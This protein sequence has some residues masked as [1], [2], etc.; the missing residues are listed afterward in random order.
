MKP[1][2]NPFI[3]RS[4]ALVASIA[5]LCLG[6]AQ[7]TPY[8]WGG[9][10]LNWNDTT[11]SGWSGGPPN[12]SDTATINSG[13]VEVTAAITGTATVSIGAGGQL[14]LNANTLNV[15]ND[16]TLNGTTAGGAIVSGDRPPNNVNVLSGQ[17]TLASTSNIATWWNDK[18]LEISGKITGGGG[19]ILDRATSLGDPVGGK[20]LISGSTNDYAGGTTVNG[21]VAGSLYGYP[22]QAQVILGA[23][24]A[25]TSGSTLT[26]N[27]GRL[28]L[29]GFSQTLSDII[30]GTGTNSVRNGSATAGSLIMNVATTSSFGGI[31]G[32]GGTNEN[33]FSLTKNGIGTLT[34]SGANTY[35]GATTVSNG[36]LVVS[37]QSYFNV[38]R[39]TSIASGAVLELSNSNN[40]FTTL[41]PT[42]TVTGG[43]TFRLSGNS[44][45]NQDLNGVS[46]DRLT[47][48][49]DAGGLIDLQGTSRLT[50]GGWQEVKWTDNKAS[51]NIAS[52]AT[53]DV[54]D[55]QA[56]IIDALSGSGTVD[57]ALVGPSPSL[58]QVGVA[59][60][61]ETF[62]GTIKNTAGQLALTKVGSGTQTLSGTNSY[63]GATTVNGGI[64][65]VTGSTHATSAVTVGGSA[66]TALGT[67]KLTGSGTINGTV[68][69]KSAGGGAAG[70]LSAGDA[71]T[72]SKIGTLTMGSSLTF[73]SSSIFEWDINANKDG[74][75]VGIDDGTAGTDFDNVTVTGAIN[76][77]NAA[78]FKVVL[79]TGV[80]ITNAFWSESNVTQ[81]WNIATI[82]GKSFTTG[83]FSPTV[84]TN[85]DISSYGSFTISGSSL[86][87]TAVPEPTSALAGLLITAGLLRRRRK[88]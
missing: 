2:N 60:G 13:S 4:L 55:G 50:N 23:N 79:G 16:I 21:R 33:N 86:T 61:S 84:Q 14:W 36:T 77:D 73:E 22:G 35:T 49:M 51:M 10:S 71:T 56:V 66:A 88:F 82:F 53:L 68:T 46:G 12:T 15:S 28:Y 47:F 24:N 32:G 85:T 72:S 65:N 5:F 62:S 20:F 11:A 38:G 19:L 37:G 9:G 25:L 43:G 70:I 34:L 59:N 8:T 67:P 6:S 29:N 57:K 7:A 63:S 42:S 3:R 45:I 83:A 41:M 31:M 18:T 58:L 75:G 52:G 74:D 40:T 48:A 27:A 80:D 26:L 17:I 1:D 44:T 87:W 64:L 69:V 30:N 78:I 81:T 54:W 39:A 76:V